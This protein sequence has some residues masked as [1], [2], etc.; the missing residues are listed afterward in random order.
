M[1]EIEL[2]S[3]DKITLKK[4]IK[5]DLFLIILFFSSFILVIGIIPLILLILTEPTESFLKRSS[6]IMFL[7]FIPFI[8]VLWKVFTIY[9]DIKSGMKLRFEISKYEIKHEK[10]YLALVDVKSQMKFEIPEYLIPYI[11]IEMPIKIEITKLS[12]Q[13]LFISNGEENY[14][15][16]AE[17]DEKPQSTTANSR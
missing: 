6:F 11:R 7:L 8:G 16:K 14:I 3:Q 4:Y 2:T 15:E 10:K 1:N 9:R 5:F 12:K 17:M 13:L